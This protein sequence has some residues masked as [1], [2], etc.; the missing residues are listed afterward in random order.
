MFG[1]YIQRSRTA[2]LKHVWMP[3][4][5]M[6]RRISHKGPIYSLCVCSLHSHA[7]FSYPESLAEMGRWDL[8]WFS[9]NL[10][11]LSMYFDSGFI[12]LAS[13]SRT[14]QGSTM[15]V[16]SQPWKSSYSVVT[17]PSLCARCLAKL[18]PCDQASARAVRTAENKNPASSGT[19]RLSC[20]L[21]ARC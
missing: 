15:N 9:G 1:I 17:R 21:M 14:E 2:T 10:K 13:L 16:F 4:L 3:Q 7:G 5:R 12:F 20:C 19:R 11:N 18:Q 8:G 6:H